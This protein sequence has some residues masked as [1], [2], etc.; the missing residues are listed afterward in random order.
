MSEESVSRRQWVIHAA[1]LVAAIVMMMGTSR[2]VFGGEVK[3]PK[4]LA[5]GAVLVEA[6]SPSNKKP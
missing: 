2:S 6:A 3:S 4:R 5:V 1:V